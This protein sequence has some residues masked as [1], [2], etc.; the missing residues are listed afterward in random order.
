MVAFCLGI[1]ADG[2]RQQTWNVLPFRLSDQQHASTL[3]QDVSASCME[4]RSGTS[5]T[6]QNKEDSKQNRPA[7]WH[8]HYTSLLKSPNT[9]I[10]LNRSARQR[11]PPRACTSR[12]FPPSS[13]RGSTAPSP[14]LA[15]HLPLPYSPHSHCPS[16][17]SPWY[18]APPPLPAPHGQGKSGSRHSTQS[19]RSRR[20]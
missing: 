7:R 3:L 1:T 10:P 5:Q 15:F 16:R 13:Y 19:R 11:H 6:S 4:A 18:H 14:P 17:S 20:P 2:R 9:Q 12:T 8:Q